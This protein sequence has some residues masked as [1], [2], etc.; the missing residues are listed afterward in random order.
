MAHFEEPVAF[1]EA[2]AGFFRDRSRRA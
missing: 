1:A 2:I